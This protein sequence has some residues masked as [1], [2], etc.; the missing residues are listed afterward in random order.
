MRDLVLVVDDDADIRNFVRSSLESQD[1][2]VIEA[3]NALETM[4]K[5]VNEKP[6][7]IIL[8][9]GIGQPDGLEVCREIRKHSEIP[10]IM[11]TVRH[12][13]IDEAMSLAAGANDFLRKPVS[14]TI[15]GLRVANQLR[16]KKE[17]NSQAL[18]VLKAGEL[19]L[20]LLTRELRV[21]ET[22]VPITRT[23]FDF[24]HLLMEEPN[25]VFTRAQVSQA[26]GIS[27]EFTSDHLLDTHASRLRIK[28]L[29]AG[30][31]RAISAVR[32]VGYRLI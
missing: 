14:K 20:D 21:N 31:P 17:D 25:R 18:T 9:I 1:F 24:I 19:S 27:A 7:L 23:E 30:G 11:L 15:L 22:V 2:R 28:I 10:I 8:E 3:V 12:D 13:E 26:I 5:L 4:V 6:H 32:A 29:N 16:S